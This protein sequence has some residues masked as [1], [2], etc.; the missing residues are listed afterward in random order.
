M[1]KIL[2]LLAFVLSLTSFSN[3]EVEITPIPANIAPV[4]ENISI[5]DVGNEDFI[6]S[7]LG[8]LEADPE[9]MEKMSVIGEA[10]DNEVLKSSPDWVKVEQLYNELSVYTNKVSVNMMKTLKEVGLDKT[11]P[12]FEAEMNN[13][14]MSD[15]VLDQGM[16]EN[17]VNEKEIMDAIKKG[18]T[19]KEIERMEELSGRISLEIEKENPKWD[20]VENDYNELSKYT[21]KVTVIIMQVEN[22]NKNGAQ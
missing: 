5:S 20:E 10:V 13:E 21:N 22:K 19:V 8:S 1:K 14:I 18:M 11:E 9:I 12:N 4:I 16:E 7:V 6:I 17:A 15:M 3:E 2:V